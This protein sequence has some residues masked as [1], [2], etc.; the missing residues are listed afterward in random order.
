MLP[1]VRA[2]IELAVETDDDGGTT[3]RRR[4]IER[5]LQRMPT[6]FEDPAKR[7]AAD[8]IEYP[9]AKLSRHAA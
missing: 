6:R 5:L 1:A 3:D 9:I 2:A 4:C 7:V 8:D